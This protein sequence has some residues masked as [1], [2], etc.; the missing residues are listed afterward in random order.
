MTITAFF[1]F[2]NGLLNLG[3][4]IVYAFRGGWRMVI[5]YVALAVANLALAGVR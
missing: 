5:F 3:A 1:P 4:G 2:A